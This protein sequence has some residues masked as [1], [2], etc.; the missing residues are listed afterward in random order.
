MSSRIFVFVH[1]QRLEDI[2][3]LDVNQLEPLDS[4]GQNETSTADA[5]EMTTRGLQ[6]EEEEGGGRIL[7]WIEKR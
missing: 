4:K 5:V 6:R 2:Q 7:E 3:R 1:W